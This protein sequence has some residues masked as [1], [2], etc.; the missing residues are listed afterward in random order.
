[1]QGG[2]RADV[3]T[4]MEVSSLRPRLYACPRPTQSYCAGRATC[5]APSWPC[6]ICTNPVVID[7]GQAWHGC[8][9][10]VLHGGEGLGG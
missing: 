9:H 5:H 10:H 7:C 6:V 2:D 3:E 1:V 4:A 8:S